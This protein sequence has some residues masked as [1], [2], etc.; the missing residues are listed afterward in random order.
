[1]KLLARNIAVL[2]FVI[3]LRTIPGLIGHAAVF[4]TKGIHLWLDV[5]DRVGIYLKREGER[6]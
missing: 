4:I 3:V 1:M 5:C 6:F 2:P